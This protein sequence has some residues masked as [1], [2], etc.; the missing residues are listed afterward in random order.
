MKKII[1]I[2][3]ILLIGLFV[4]GGCTATVQQ[5]SNQQ[6]NQ[7]QPEQQ[8]NSQQANSNN[9]LQPPALPEE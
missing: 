7:A 1:A 4:L 8:Q 2:L 3:F 5:S 6:P 9:N